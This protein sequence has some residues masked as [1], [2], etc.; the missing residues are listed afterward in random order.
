MSSH[1]RAQQYKK[2]QH[3]KPINIG[4]VR[5]VKPNDRDCLRLQSSNKLDIHNIY[6]MELYLVRP[7][8][9]GPL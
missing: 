1:A 5:S 6:I 9:L 7:T 4:S 3:K 2:T 8:T